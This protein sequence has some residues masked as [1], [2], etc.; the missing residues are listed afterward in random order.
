MSR[1]AE[2]DLQVRMDAFIEIDDTDNLIARS[3]FPHAR[4]HDTDVRHRAYL[5]WSLPQTPMLCFG[6]SPCTPVAGAGE[7]LGPAHPEI[8]ITTDELANVANHLQIPFVFGEHHWRLA[9]D[10]DGILLAR[11]DLCMAAGGRHRRPLV[12]GVPM[13]A[14]LIRDSGCAEI[15]PRLFINYEPVSAEGLIGPCPPLEIDLSDA[16]RL[17]DILDPPDSVPAHLWL[18]GRIVVHPRC[19][20]ERRLQPNIAATLYMGESGALFVGSH[21][22]RPEDIPRDRV[23]VLWSFDTPERR[24]ATLF[25]D[26]RGDREYNLY[27]REIRTDGLTQRSFTIPL[28]SI[29]GTLT[30]VTSFGPPPLYGDKQAIYIDGRAR[31]LTVGELF[32]LGRDYDGVRRVRECA[33]HITEV[34]LR[35]RAGKTVCMPIARAGLRRAH[36]RA[37]EL[38]AVVAGH[39]EPFAERVGTRL[40]SHAAPLGRLNVVV[41]FVSLHKSQPAVLYMSEGVAIG[42]ADAN[43]THRVAVD[44]AAPILR[45]FTAALGFEPVAFLA[46]VVDS[47]AFPDES[48]LVVACPTGTALIPDVDPFRWMPLDRI[49]AT[50]HPVAALSVSTTFSMLSHE[51]VGRTARSRAPVRR[52]P[53]PTPL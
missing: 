3:M 34:Q 42:I 38:L 24:H 32:K 52:H 10:H 51:C 41:S 1:V 15:R 16:Q 11:V 44:L 12:D 50:Q 33:P 27:L 25:M 23:W 28:R 30:T 39:A 6:C 14:E 26:T 20:S 31:R 5:R 22:Q 21:V 29:Y 2:D 18:H 17:V 37:S 49:P 13:G 40:A 53:M 48:T 8:A 36:K 19:S 45:Q 46:G 7:M 47:A 4:Y 43:A 35:K 9:A